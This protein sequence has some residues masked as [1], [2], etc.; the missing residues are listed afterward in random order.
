ML[1]VRPEDANA[2]IKSF[3]FF[4]GIVRKSIRQKDKLIADNEEK[5]KPIAFSVSDFLPGKEKMR[6]MTISRTSSFSSIN[7]RLAH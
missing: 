6:Q 1:Q 2:E 3:S 4:L 5:G 7:V